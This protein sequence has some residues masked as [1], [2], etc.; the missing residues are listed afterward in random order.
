MTQVPE[1]SALRSCG[2]NTDIVVHTTILKHGKSHSQ[3]S[4][5]TVQAYG[6]LQIAYNHFNRELFNGQLPDC[7][8]T[9]QRKADHVFGYY[10]HARFGHRDVEGYTTDEI[11]LNPR[12]FQKRTIEE[13]LSTLVHEMV[14]L[15]QHHDP[16]G[17]P[18]RVGYHNKTWSKKMQD[19]GLRPTHN[20]QPDGRL[21]GQ[22][23]SHLIVSG[24]P[25]DLS[26]KRLIS[27]QFRISWYD[28]ISEM[29]RVDI[30]GKDT[31]G[32]GEP[33]TAGRRAKFSCR[34]CA[35]NA[36]GKPTLKLVCG[37]CD[38]AMTLT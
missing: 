14:H 23:M 38:S 32:T 24:G 27:E 15:W 30:D 22:N 5:P 19:L 29:S 26:A 13:T 1:N 21:H 7:M 36:W 12:H 25:F 2:P 16:E 34:K 8:I 35:A 10:S 37:T 28:R 9:L 31:N 17:N 33:V 6:E 4:L 18:S 11:A 20:G 3:H